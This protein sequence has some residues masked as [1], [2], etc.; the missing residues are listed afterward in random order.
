[1]LPGS[2]SIFVPGP[3]VGNAIA[4]A[5]PTY[6]DLCVTL[7]YRSASQDYSMEDPAVTCG[8]MTKKS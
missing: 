2:K 3:A 6:P 5:T 4:V 1:M 7:K 8:T